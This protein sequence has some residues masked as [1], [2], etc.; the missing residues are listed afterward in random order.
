MICAAMTSGAQPRVW[1]VRGL[2]AE[3]FPQAASFA[4]RG[5]GHLIA[6]HRVAVGGDKFNA[7]LGIVEDIE[8][9]VAPC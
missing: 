1:S 5:H 7:Q 2:G 9:H 3:E 6:I 8:R 4:E